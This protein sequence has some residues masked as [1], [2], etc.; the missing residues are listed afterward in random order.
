M[1]YEVPWVISHTSWHWS[2][3]RQPSR[4]LKRYYTSPSVHAL[5]TR[6]C[7]SLNLCQL[8]EVSLQLEGLLVVIG[9]MQVLVVRVVGCL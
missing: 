5:M 2:N 6:S 9:G 1:R 7:L 8:R 4:V 3:L